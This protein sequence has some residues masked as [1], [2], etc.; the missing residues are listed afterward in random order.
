MRRLSFIMIVALGLTL[1]GAADL[2]GEGEIT[3]GARYTHVDDDE[4]RFR[5]DHF[6]GDGL[7][8]GIENLYWEEVDGDTRFEAQIRAFVEDEYLL[9]L[10]YSREDVG[11]VRLEVRSERRYYDGSNEAWD[12]TAYGLTGSEVI[13]DNRTSP[14]GVIDDGFY[15]YGDFADRPDGSLYTER[16]E[17]TIEAGLTMPDM[18]EVIVGWHRWERDGEELLLRGERARVTNPGDE[19]F[20]EFFPRTRSVSALAT[21]DG[22][23][24]LYYLELA[25]TVGEKYNL[26]FRQEYETYR[27]SQLI[28]FPRYLWD[29][30]KESAQ[31]E[32]YRT[33]EDEPDFENFVSLVTFDT[34][35]DDDTYLAA[36]YMYNNLENTT[37][38]EVVRPNRGTSSQINHSVGTRTDNTRESH[39]GAVGYRRDGILGVE[40]LGVVIGVRVEDADT[41]S[42]TFLLAG[43]TT[44][45]ESMTDLEEIRVEENVELIYT[46]IKATVV[47]LEADLEQRDLD[48][49]EYED[50]GSHEIFDPGHYDSGIQFFDYAAD[51][52]H[53]NAEYSLK[54]VNRGAKGCKVTAI[55]RNKR[56]DRD[57]DIRR[58]ADPRF[59]PGRI[60]GYRI[61]GD[62]VSV[63]L[64]SRQM[65]PG[66]SVSLKYQYSQ[67]DIETDFAQG[68]SQDWEISR[69]SASVAGAPAN[70]LFLLTSF[71]YEMYQ[72]DTPVNITD[73]ASH[74]AEGTAAYDYEGDYATFLLNADCVLSEDVTA[75]ADYQLT[76]SMGDDNEYRYH[77]VTGAVS[78]QAT[79]TETIKVACE[80]YDFD[81]EAGDGFD[82]YTATGASVS[83]TRVF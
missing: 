31:I 34:Q 30:T 13:P 74:W 59:F 7:L 55:Y 72:L 69:I 66:C 8:G 49:S 58:D 42:E 78:V 46:G 1:V 54:V 28:E 64:D 47:S 24:D 40:E 68:E 73:P 52:E 11:Y 56:L 61:E 67:E 27:D 48:W 12:P 22:V 70:R 23:S 16:R 5:E 43:G 37:A 75:H 38:R 19:R 15:D 26:R 21:I 18:P 14:P 33:F 83:Y 62:E 32:Q 20:G 36:G 44:P 50:V 82:D 81:D 65:V 60:G 25:D 17:L 41:D 3:V 45:R 63:A 57:Y 80:F 71:I 39:V 6:L 29:Q 9:K 35:L 10:K 77:K 53:R 79:E 76:S 51:I 2:R 4:G